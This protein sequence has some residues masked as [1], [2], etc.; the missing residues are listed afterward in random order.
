MTPDPLHTVVRHLHRLTA[1]AGASALTDAQ[2]LERWVN[3]RDEAAFEVL[4]WRHGPLVLGTCRR[5]LSRAED[6]EDAFQATFLALVRKAA[7]IGRRESVAAWLHKVAYRVALAA[8]AARLRVKTVPP[9]EP[10]S[11]DPAEDV[12]VR[13]LRGVLDEEVARLPDKYRV[14]F[15]LCYLQGKTNAEA[16]AELGCPHGTV[17]TR[18]RWARQ[19]LRSR[20]ARRGV[21]LT[22]AALAIV[23]AEAGHTPAALVGSVV[24]AAVGTVPGAVSAPVSALADGVLRE[25]FQARVRRMAAAVVVLVLL[26]GGVGALAQSVGALPRERAGPVRANENARKPA[27]PEGLAEALPPGALARL[28]TTRLRHG[29][30]VLSV[31]LS[32]D[33]KVVASAGGDGVVRMWDTR[34]GKELR[35]FEQTDGFTAAALLDAGKTLVG[36]DA[37]GTLHVWD[38]AT[39]KELRSWKAHPGR[40]E[41]IAPA[42][43]GRSFLTLGGL[44]DYT[45]RL[46]DSETG[47]ESQQFKLEGGSVHSAHW[48][49]DGKTLLAFS[50]QGWARVWDV[51]S[52]KVLSKLE[53]LQGIFGEKA[54]DGKG[55]RREIKPAALSPDGR[56]VAAV[57][58]EGRITLVSVATGRKVTQFGPAEGEV[59]RIEYL[60]GGGELITAGRDGV[61]HV[62]DVGTGEEVRQLKGHAGVVHCSTVSAGGKLLVTGGSDHL[63]RLWDL[64]RGEELL[65]PTGPAS[66]VRA[67]DFS[68]NGD[69]L[70]YGT[71]GGD[72]FLW[73]NLGRK[74]PVV[75]HGHKEPVGS[76]SFAPDGKTLATGGAATHDQGEP[77]ARVWDVSTGK[78][79]GHVGDDVVPGLTAVRYTPDARLLL[80]ATQGQ[81]VRLVE[82]EWNYNLVWQ[83]SQD[84]R[85]VLSP[86]GRF[87]LIGSVDTGFLVID[88]EIRVGG[89]RLPIKEERDP[90][91]PFAIKFSQGRVAAFSADGKVLATAG[92]GPEV[93]LWE[94]ATGKERGSLKAWKA[95][96]AVGAL[97]FSPDGRALAVGGHDRHVWL[98]D[99]GTGEQ[100]ADF[101]GHQGPITA[102]A[103]TRDAQRLASGSD[104]TT[105]LVWDVAEVLKKRPAQTKPLA[106]GEADKL[107]AALAGTDA[108]EAAQAIVR[109]SELGEKGVEFVKERLRPAPA[110]DVKEIT[111]WAWM[112]ASKE[113][114][115]RDRALYD[116]TQAGE[117]GEPLLRRVL[118]TAPEKDLRDVA[119]DHLWGS[120]KG[121]SSPEQLRWLRAVEVLE[122]A[123][124]PGRV[125][126]E[127]FVKGPEG[128][129]L[130]EEARAA[131]A[132]VKQRTGEH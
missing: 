102:L 60:P 81:Y 24:R 2:L 72:V 8:R 104:D 55:G 14:P 56:T 58:P 29:G 119:R 11:A 44:A 49:G 25:M 73:D 82:G 31:S 32:P 9:G 109:L 7:S 67:V 13:E 116:L 43:A 12:A 15:V 122:R 121:E 69:G 112:L 33:D 19:R 88:T 80:L 111:K 30:E 39:G 42:P 26:L 86:D 118:R 38:A 4:A 51:D 35:R 40:V 99:V 28:G 93:R 120:L 68:P 74:E 117:L 18:L 87:G 36:A 113:K 3:Q 101:T 66:P 17:L 1:P 125:A 46:W 91:H 107:W 59:S 89:H 92:D 22:A 34:T 47:K 106:D 130:A 85:L 98:F 105:V 63:V 129:P 10:A 21:T 128:E 16:A 48:A 45:L 64:A 123:G 124:D 71:V 52:G 62:W 54:D 41:Q 78:E 61:M 57:P 132:R 100:L 77:W 53:E 94:V 126:L 75:L 115:E 23:L 95:G 127:E 110:A 103:F 131:L 70:A 79:V 114:N 90:G 76:V 65:P 50:D 27:A 96:G 84:G 6:A 97:A 37:A 108:A 20:L 5:L 83:F